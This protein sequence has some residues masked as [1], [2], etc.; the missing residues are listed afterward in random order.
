MLLLFLILVRILAA[1]YKRDN[2]NAASEV[3]EL[4][5]V[6]AMMKDDSGLLSL[7]SDEPSG[8]KEGEGMLF[9]VCV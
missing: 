9:H 1:V 7:S 4:I 3:I 5:I 6:V 2:P 8:E